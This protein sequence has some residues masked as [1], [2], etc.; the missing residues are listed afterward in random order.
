MS[1]DP[2]NISL[3]TPAKRAKFEDSSLQSSSNPPSPFTLYCTQC[4]SHY[5]YPLASIITGPGIAVSPSLTTQPCTP[6][7]ISNKKIYEC[8]VCKKVYPRPSALKTHMRKHTGEKP[9]VCSIC[10]KTFAD[11]GNLKTHERIHT[12]EKPFL[13]EEC[14]TKFTTQG[15]LTDHFRKHTKERPFICDFPECGKSFPRSS[16]LKNHKR[17]HTGERPFECKTCGK[18][19]SESGNFESHK[20]VH[21]GE[22]PYKC[23]I[24]G[25]DKAFKTRGQLSDH[26]KTKQHLK[27]DN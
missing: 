16:I 26:K 17:M 5:Q 18:K 22:R 11:K 1:G 20:R 14:G 2:E 3:E 13:C 19:F 25:C 23:D 6:E 8:K 4:S 24:D 15:H 27:R 7:I 12:G 21:T 9:F 10:T